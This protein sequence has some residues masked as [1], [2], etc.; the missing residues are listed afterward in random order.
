MK[1]IN[2]FAIVKE[3][4]YSVQYDTEVLNEFAKCFELWNDP[5]YLREFFEQH[6]EDLDNEFWNG[7]SIEEAIKKT[8]EDARLF[9][10]ELLYIAESGKTERLETLSTLFEPLSKGVINENL[11]KDKAKGMKRHSWLRV[12]AIRIEAN[13]FVVSGG[14]IKLTPTMNERNHLILELS[15]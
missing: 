7:L 3:S 1:I 12:Y 13:L 15:N 5:I 14:A 4:L 8:K 11:E 10:E 6:K 9:E 2:T